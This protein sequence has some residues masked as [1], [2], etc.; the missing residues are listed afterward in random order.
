M[1]TLFVCAFALLCTITLCAQEQKEVQA[2]PEL[3]EWYSIKGGFS[4]S[5]VSY[6]PGFDSSGGGLNA[7]VVGKGDT[8]PTW[9]NRFPYDT[10]N[11]FT[12]VE[13]SGNYI[14]YGDFNGDG[15]RDYWGAYDRL[16]K[17]IKN[18]SFPNLKP[19]TNYY[20]EGLGYR[21]VADYNGDGYDDM[22]QQWSGA[23][24]TNC[25]LFRIVWGGKDLKKLKQST[26]GNFTDMKSGK[27]IGVYQN[28][29]KQWRV[30][31]FQSNNGEEAFFLYELQIKKTGEIHTVELKELDVIRKFKTDVNERVFEPLSVRLLTNT[32]KEEITVHA[33]RAKKGYSEIWRIVND[34]FSES[35]KSTRIGT[36]VS[37]SLLTM[38]ITG[39]GAEN[40]IQPFINQ[41]ERY[42]AVYSSSVWND[43]VPKA[44]IPY[45]S[46]Y[47]WLTCTGIGDVN[48]DGINDVAGGFDGGMVVYLGT[49]IL[50][51]LNAAVVNTFSIHQNEPNPIT[52]DRKTRLPL[53]LN[54]AGNYTLQLYNIRGTKVKT[55]FDGFLNDGEI[56]LP[57]DLTGLPSGMYIVKMSNGTQ[58][59]ERAIMIGE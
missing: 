40:Y 31:A 22:L 19:D 32:E 43:T 55:L 24:C 38:S 6:L 47:K 14:V 33:I 49:N 44:K 7:I 36:T 28:E 13:R 2:L 57:L 50:N 27:M 41:S 59:R 18:G 11:H 53:S 21:F 20:T 45:S 9:Y 54:K 4:N 34:T 42:H 5:I 30:I 23:P 52:K 10:T 48:G 46:S 37:S 8:A 39:E 26:V 58:T 25:P 29:N 56:K 12:W 51:T 35:R 17:G 15:I 1:K 16:Y 3:Q